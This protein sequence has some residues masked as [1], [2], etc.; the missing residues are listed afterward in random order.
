MDSGFFSPIFGVISI[1][2]ACKQARADKSNGRNSMR[3][4][5]IIVGCINGLDPFVLHYTINTLKDIVPPWP[6]PK[7]NLLVTIL[8]K[9]Q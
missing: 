5:V 8:K 7:R 2:V 9:D 1:S 6:L 3:T 4:N